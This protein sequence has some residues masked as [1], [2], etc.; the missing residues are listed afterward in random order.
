MAHRSSFLTWWQKRAWKCWLSLKKKQSK[1]PVTLTRY[2]V[3]YYLW[4]VSKKKKRV[5][6]TMLPREHA[7]E[8][9][10]DPTLDLIKEKMSPYSKCDLRKMEVGVL[11]YRDGEGALQALSVEKNP[12]GTLT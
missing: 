11:A 2:W 10:A 3:F 4:F 8:Q 12:R 9:K 7:S 5:V 1:N 6:G